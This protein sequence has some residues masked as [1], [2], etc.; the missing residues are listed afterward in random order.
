M[1]FPLK[2]QKAT[3]LIAG[4]N[5]PRTSGL[6]PQWHTLCLLFDM[7]SI[8]PLAALLTT[9]MLMTACSST[10]DMNGPAGAGTSGASRAGGPSE[11]SQT[12]GSTT[13]Q[14]QHN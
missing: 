11:A 9:L 10:G 14:S 1:V 3:H 2:L 6:P 4:K 7:K 13:G 8:I 12:T 5:H